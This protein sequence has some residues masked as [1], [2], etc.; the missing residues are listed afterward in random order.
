[1]SV[2]QADVIDFVSIDEE[3]NVVLTISDHLEWDMENEHL[4]ILQDKINAYLSSI[5]SGD[6]YE[7]YA[8]RPL[9]FLVLFVL[10]YLST[11]YY[12]NWFIAYG[13]KLV[14]RVST[15]RVKPALVPLKPADEN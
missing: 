13:R 15:Y 10:A 5:E 9:L 11:N 6:I 1:M 8:K 12:E 2:E 14:R 7:K 4:L 3:D